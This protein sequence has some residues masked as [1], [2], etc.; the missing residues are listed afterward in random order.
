MKRRDRK[1]KERGRD[2]RK[3]DEGIGRRERERRWEMG[4]EKIDLP[5]SLSTV[6][7][8]TRFFAAFDRTVAA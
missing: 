5:S 2:R 4:R 1:I 6:F 7:R 8:R 3:R